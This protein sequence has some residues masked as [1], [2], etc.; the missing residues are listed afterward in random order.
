M[1]NK[2]LDKVLDPNIRLHKYFFK[3]LISS[4]VM[5]YNEILF[6]IIKF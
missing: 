6:N 1:I 5:K 3:N 2:C 4:N